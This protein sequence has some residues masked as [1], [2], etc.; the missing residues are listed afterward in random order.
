[1]HKKCYRLIIIVILMLPI[2]QY[3][4]A[5]NAFLIKGEIINASSTKP[6]AYATVALFKTADSSLVKTTLTDSTGGF[7]FERL[8]SVSYYLKIRHLLFKDTT[9]IIDSSVLIK[10]RSLTI[11]LTPA[12]KQQ[13]KEITI[14]GKKPL[15]ERKIDRLIFNVAD[16]VN[17]I[18]LNVLDML[19]QTPMVKVDNEIVS[20]VGKGKVTIMINDKIMKMPAEALAA[21]LKALPAESVERIE[22]IT[23]PPAMYSA[24]GQGGIINIIL[25]KNK[26]LGYSGTAN[27]T[28]Q[29]TTYVQGSSAINMWYNKKNIRYFGSVFSFLGSHGPT[30]LN[31]VFYPTLIQ[32]SSAKQ[33]EYSQ[34]AMG[35]IGFEADL[36]SSTTLGVSYN[37]M[38][39]FPY[40]YTTIHTQF[41]DKQTQRLDSASLQNNTNKA[42]FALQSAN[43]HLVKKLDTAS[44]KRIVIDGDW[45]WNS[46]DAPNRIET[47]IYD[48]DNSPLGSL[49]TFSQSNLV[50]GIYSLNGVVYLPKKKH[51]WS[52]GTRVDF[53]R[54]N[55]A[56][57]L[58]INDR[59]HQEENSYN[60]FVYQENTQALFVNF[61]SDLSK[62]WSFQS[63]LR[64]EY[65]Q[66]KGISHSVNDSTSMH[67]YLKLFPTIYLLYHL[68]SKNTLSVNYGRRINRPGFSLF[69]PYI[70]YQDQYTYL[71]GNPNL[72]P[73]I[74]NNFELT[75]TYS[76]NLNISIQYNFSNNKASF[77][78]LPQDDFQSII[79]K[80]TNDLSTRSF[81]FSSSYVL[82]KIKWL[83][84]LNS[85]EI[86]YNKTISTSKYTDPTISGWTGS[87]RSNN[88]FYF[89]KEKTL[90]GGLSFR[91]QFPGI[92]GLSKYPGS[93]HFYLSGKYS[94]LNKRLQI[95]L[96][97][98]DIFKMI[99]PLKYYV[100]DVLY[101]T[102]AN[103]DSRRL[104]LTFQ[105]NFGNSKLK[106]GQ[107]HSVNP[108]KGR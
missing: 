75:E 107:S 3:G 98:S 85:L 93:Y 78:P 2:T 80:F 29:K 16:N 94:L 41:T 7:H 36:S 84:S 12:G 96:R 87:F 102:K 79:Y 32:K 77:I 81:V 18:G 103:G 11:R 50:T 95:G 63:G 72:K 100:N 55:Q 82:N 73:S 6:I 47:E 21:Y 38:K 27:L 35:T 89:N 58:K 45:S 22:V 106:K 69:N 88:S 15:I 57:S 91:Y 61:N 42:V 74:S 17:M 28:L 52:F 33:R 48:P 26:K 49:Q 10:N 60:K 24:E 71:Q 1:M 59:D 83:E 25:K 34:G 104:Y 54:D 39:S 86:Y 105:Y 62:R 14:T 19:A 40:Q 9:I 99:T 43:V 64:G 90:V 68:N 108:N 13:L 44:A 46:S 37:L 70:R 65:T 5:Q 56:I 8:S 4:F 101:S 20:I 23:N 97:L 76:Q 67:A 31:S 92:E 66:T 53:I 51:E 30:Y